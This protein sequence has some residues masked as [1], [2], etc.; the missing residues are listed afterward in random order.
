MWCCDQLCSGT[1]PPDGVTIMVVLQ[2]HDGL[3]HADDIVSD[4][5]RRQL[6]AREQALKQSEE[7]PAMTAPQAADYKR[8]LA[9][10]MQPCESVTEALRRLRPPPAKGAPVKGPKKGTPPSISVATAVWTA[11]STYLVQYH[12][13]WTK[14]P[15]CE[16]HVGWTSGQA[17][18]RGMCALWQVILVPVHSPLDASTLSVSTKD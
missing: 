12:G 3:L 10:L 2:A 18:H 6:E 5:V 8:Q 4:R 16:G 1:D 11:T 9:A 14:D 15:T 7:A 17:E 13:V